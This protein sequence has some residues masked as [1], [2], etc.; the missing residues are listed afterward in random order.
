MHSTILDHLFGAA[1]VP[2]QYHQYPFFFIHQSFLSFFLLSS[3]LLRIHTHHIPQMGHWS[4][5][6]SLWSDSEVKNFTSDEN[7]HV[8]SWW[9]KDL[10]KYISLDLATIFTMSQRALVNN[11]IN[12]RLCS[13]RIRYW[14]KQFSFFF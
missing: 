14:F 4:E 9:M 8:L 13:L 1:R 12:I 2:L 7:K 6:Y 10:W 5:L 11:N 3:L